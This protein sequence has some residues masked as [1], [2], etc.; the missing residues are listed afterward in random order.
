MCK[1]EEKYCPRCRSAFECKAGDI[2]QCQCAGVSLTVAEKQFIAERW[3]DCLCRKCLLELKQPEVFFKE[4][5]FP[6]AGR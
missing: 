5:Y 6:H 2:A 3:T 1:H 4:K